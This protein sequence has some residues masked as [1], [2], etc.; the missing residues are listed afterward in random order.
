MACCGGNTFGLLEYAATTAGGSRPVRVLA[1][2]LDGPRAMLL[3]QNASL[4]YPD[5]PTTITPGSGGS[6]SVAAAAAD[7]RTFLLAPCDGDALEENAHCSVIGGHCFFSLAAAM[8]RDSNVGS[9]QPSQSP[10]PLADV[11]FFDPPWGG[12]QYREAAA[13]TFTFPLRTEAGTAGG[14]LFVPEWCAPCGAT[15][16]TAS[17]VKDDDAIQ[18]QQDERVWD[19]A[20]FIRAA[21]GLPVSLGDSSVGNAS[22]APTTTGRAAAKASVIAVKVGADAAT[23]AWAQALVEDVVGLGRSTAPAAAAAPVDARG[24]PERPFP[25]LFNFGASTRLYCFVVNAAMD[26]EMGV[27][28]NAT[29]DALVSRIFDWNV[30]VAQREGKPRFYDFEKR[31]WIELKKWIDTPK[32]PSTD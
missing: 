31:R 17:D 8:E 5:T 26:A 25:F 13:R 16:T 12:P 28:T 29:L 19:L 18:K 9:P 30:T 1:S 24:V 27:V 21:L 3:K 10:G 15:T 20:A 7:G 4:L 14:D 11:L 2:E 6:A 32:A 22:S 23:T